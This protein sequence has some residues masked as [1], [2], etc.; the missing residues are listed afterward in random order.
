[1]SQRRVGGSTAVVASARVNVLLVIVV[2]VTAVSAVGV[3]WARS[4]RSG[5]A[6]D[7]PLDGLRDLYD[8]D[9]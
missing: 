6:L 3:L 8:Q 1:M 7:R 4:R 2:L 9:G 5:D